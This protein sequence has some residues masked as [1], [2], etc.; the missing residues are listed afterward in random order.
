MRRYVIGDIHGCG[1]ALR[2]LVDEISPTKDDE[3]IFLGDYVD[4]GPDSRGVID[5]LIEL[6]D[7]YR[8]ILLRGNHEIMLSGVVFRNLDPR[9][10]WEAAEKQPSQAT[11]ATFARYQPHTWNS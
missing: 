8:V 10:G 6:R 5:Q 2:S 7:H 4:R 1:K 11:V 9:S 3:L